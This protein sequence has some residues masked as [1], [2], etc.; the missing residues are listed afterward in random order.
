M[1]PSRPLGVAAAAVFD[2]LYA[3][4][5]SSTVFCFFHLTPYDRTAPIGANTYSIGSGAVRTTGYS[6]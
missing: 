5:G 2:L 1:I 6:R 4:S 3:P